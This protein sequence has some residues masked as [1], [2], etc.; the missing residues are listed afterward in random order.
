[1]YQQDV[2][3]NVYPDAITVQ[4]LIPELVE[5]ARRKEI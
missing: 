1:M 4:L 3:K 5:E 2:G